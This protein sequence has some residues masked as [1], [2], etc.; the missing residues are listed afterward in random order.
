V[1]HDGQSIDLKAAGR[2]DVSRRPSSR[3]IQPADG[4]VGVWTAY[5][6]PVARKGRLV[7]GELKKNRVHQAEGPPGDRPHVPR[8][9]RSNEIDAFLKRAERQDEPPARR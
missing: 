6:R 9:R 4:H 3:V 2:R 8:Y 7:S 5:I 1:E